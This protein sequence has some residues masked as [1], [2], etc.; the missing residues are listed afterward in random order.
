MAGA[1]LTA[2]QLSIT[3]GDEVDLVA[4]P[5]PAPEIRKRQCDAQLKER[6]YE[7]KVDGGLLDPRKPLVSKATHALARWRTQGVGA[8]KHTVRVTIS[9]S[10]ALPSGEEESFKFDASLDIT[11]QPRTG[12]ANVLR[13]P[14]D[15]TATGSNGG[16]RPV[17]TESAVTLQ[18]TAR[19]P[20]PDEI[21]WIVIRRSTRDLS[22]DNY[23]QFL[24]RVLCGEDVSLPRDTCQRGSVPPTERKSPLRLPFP[25]VDP[26]RFLKAATETFLMCNSGVFID[27]D[28]LDLL[29]EERRLEHPIVDPGPVIVGSS[30]NVF[31]RLFDR[32]REQVNGSL[33]LPYLAIIRNR[34]Q[35]VPLNGPHTE[36]FG[37]RTIDCIGILNEK[38]TNPLLVELIWS[39]W[40]EE[41]MLVQALNA[42]SM[43][44]QNR[45]LGR[46]KD[47]LAQLELDP[48][49]P[50]NNLLWGYIQ[51]EQH[52]LS[53]VRR[54]YEYDHHYGFSLHGKAVGELQ[55]ADRR[56]KFL[57]SF[58]NLLHETV[59]FYRR[60]DDTTVVADGFPL[61]NALKETHYLLAQ[62]AH[63][64]FG[65]LPSTA[66]Q[67]MLI[68]QWL[69]SR[70]EL[71]EFLGT[72]VMVPYPEP[73]MDRVDSLKT[74]LGW[75]DVSVVHF[76][77]LAVFGEQILLSVRFGGW[78]VVNDPAQA[79][80]WAR[81]WRPEV[82]GYVHAYRAVTGVDLTVELTDRQRAAERYLP[83]SVHLRNR[84]EAQRRR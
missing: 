35:E 64:Q 19:R 84:L 74:L 63:N 8:G 39:Y 22:F 38:L 17:I 30:T 70:P 56:S 80:N 76:H 75:T 59:R 27:F 78:S 61:L 32:Y 50:L 16:N 67:E 57:E 26:F 47:P 62:G 48:L 15:V 1:D 65:D 53:V 66:R 2:S 6:V 3:E 71:R 54:A 9:E 25:G 72:R 58:H 31:E 28:A 69:L 23:A 5:N 52:R 60:D 33:V 55:S 73:W 18:R 44:F 81:Y 45:R 29:E 79:A 36:E 11:V 12:E 24:D 20:T 83:P 21:L 4:S 68:Q 49:R 40:H 13:S 43:R 77:D 10:Y 42:I 7:F 34:L 51:D 82:Q 46:D 14:P 37:S 41:G